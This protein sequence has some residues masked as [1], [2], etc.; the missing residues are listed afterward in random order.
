MGDSVQCSQ[1]HWCHQLKGGRE[2][3]VRE[4]EKGRE[5]EKR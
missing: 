3:R 4:T 1:D 5:V 2:E